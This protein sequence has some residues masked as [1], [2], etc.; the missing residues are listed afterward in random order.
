MYPFVCVHMYQCVDASITTGC[1]LLDFLPLVVSLSLGISC[2]CIEVMCPIYYLSIPSVLIS[3]TT[4]PHPC[5]GAIIVSLYLGVVRS[6]FFA[7]CFFL[8]LLNLSLCDL[9]F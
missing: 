9:A 7:V 3:A 4:R 8:L 6:L 5:L 1:G 2:D